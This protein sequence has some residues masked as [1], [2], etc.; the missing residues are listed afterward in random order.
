MSKGSFVSSILLKELKDMWMKRLKFLFVCL[1]F[2]SVKAL[3]VYLQKTEGKTL[4]FTKVRVFD[5]KQIL[6][7]NTVVVQNGKI[8][9]IGKDL[10]APEMPRLLMET[11]IRFYPASLTLILMYMVPH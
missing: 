3:P 4:V 10:K 11:G 5:G 9:S 2:F 8:L 7:A 1:F 6:D